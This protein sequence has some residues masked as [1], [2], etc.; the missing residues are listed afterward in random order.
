MTQTK[1]KPIK[2]QEFGEKTV[3]PV[4][5]M[6]MGSR[7]STIISGRARM[8]RSIRSLAMSSNTVDQDAKRMGSLGMVKG[9][10]GWT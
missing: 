3:I 10:N 7:G 6:T 8:S 4:E 1:N 5:D 2:N 9:A